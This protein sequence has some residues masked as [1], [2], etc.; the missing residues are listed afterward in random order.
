MCIEGDGRS[1]RPKEALT[2]E[3]I[4][5][6]LKIILNDRK[7]KLIEIAETLRVQRYQRNVFDISCMN[8]WTCKSCVQSGCRAC[9][10]SIKS[11]NVLMIRSNF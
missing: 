6:I 3:N 8:I 10:Q 9:S 1:G 5:N 7:V 2:D 4:K 11:N